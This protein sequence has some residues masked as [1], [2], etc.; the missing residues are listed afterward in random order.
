VAALKLCLRGHVILD[1]GSFCEA[2]CLPKHP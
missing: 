2:R 1:Q